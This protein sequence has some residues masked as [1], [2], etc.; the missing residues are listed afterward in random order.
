MIDTPQIVQS[1]RQ[2]TAAIHLV[3]PRNQIQQ[4]FGPAV[5]ELLGVM[6]AQ[7][8]A[9]AGPL[10][11]YH[12]K[13]PSEVFDFDI[14]FPVAQEVKPS[15]RVVSSEVPAFRVARTLYRG[16]MEGLGQAWGALQAW[17]KANGHE[18][19]Q[20]MFERYLVGPGDTPDPAQWQT[21]LNWPLAG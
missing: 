21:E 19:Q 14:A 10:L 1:P 6:Q 13:M 18:A 5:G 4:A 15:G 8:V 9:P 3:I 2:L 7:G 11:S 12:V 16:Q 20:Q 17:I